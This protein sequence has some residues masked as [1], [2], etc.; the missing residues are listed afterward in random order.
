MKNKGLFL[1]FLGVSVLYFVTHVWGL[2][3]LPVFADEAIY[4]RWSQLIIDNWR[5][6]LFFPLNDGKTPLYM[7]L[8]VPFQF[9]FEDR[10]YAARFVSVL[11]G[12]V[13]LFIFF[14][15]AKKVTTQ[16][17]VLFF[18]MLLVTLLPFWY[19]HHRMALTE[20]LLGVTVSVSMYGAILLAQSKKQSKK[21][22]SRDESLAILL[23][24]VGVGL[25]LLTKI[26]AILNVPALYLLLLLDK[27]IERKSLLRNALLL[28]L[29]V[30][31]GLGMF[32]LL[33]VHPA[34]SQLFSR[35]GDFLYP[36]S[37]IFAGRIWDN[38]ARISQYTYFFMWYLTLPALFLLLAGLFTAST[39]R[40]VHIFFWAGVLVC[41]PI[42]LLG[43]VV[44][45][46]YFFPA[47]AYFTVAITLSFEG[48]LVYLDSFKKRL[49]FRFSVTIVIALL[50]SNI[51]T[52]S[53]AFIVPSI[54]NPD[55][56]PFL[57]EDRFQ[58]LEGWSSGHG[59][60]E[61]SNVLQEESQKSS[62]AL[63][64]EGSFGTLP[65][66]ILMYQHRTNVDALYVEGVGFPSVEFP[67]KFVERA[68]NFDR[69][70]YVANEDRVKMDMTDV[71]IVERYC[72]PYAAPCLVVWD[73]S[74][75]VK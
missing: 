48:I 18:G 37:E 35:G 24:V 16:R 2:T 56:T 1:L 9:L 50:L 29:G 34:F 36:L 66:G 32:V 62:I 39:Q 27:N 5:E 3:S 52:Q 61:L 45:P 57:V 8:L 17:S 68:K 23:L 30:F 74:D 59:I 53:F 33:K 43:K 19:F 21:M 75:L 67:E 26:P 46:R 41:L 58:Y 47:I 44:H 64:T 69:V 40:K 20:A 13:Q 42:V 51:A 70:W 12:Y 4:I 22:L 31:G 71:P 60:L 6:Y 72:R 14:L 10:L 55:T 38:I 25:G 73:I 54:S 49:L 28:T 63:A 7:W 11:I 15:I 65:D